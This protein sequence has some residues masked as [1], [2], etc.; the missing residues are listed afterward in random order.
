MNSPT[1]NKIDDFERNE[2]RKLLGQCNI[3][4]IKLF[5]RMYASIDEIPKDDIPRAIHQCEQT[6]Q[7]NKDKSK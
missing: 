5:N 3:E 7:M 2:L 4:Q 1:L 6:I